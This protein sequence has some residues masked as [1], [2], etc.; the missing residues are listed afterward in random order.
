MPKFLIIFLNLKYF[1]KL[2]TVGLYGPCWIPNPSQLKPNIDPCRT[3]A[4]I[5]YPISKKN[6]HHRRSLAL[7]YSPDYYPKPLI[8]ARPRLIFGQKK[9]KILTIELPNELHSTCVVSE[10]IHSAFAQIQN[11][12]HFSTRPVLVPKM[13]FTYRRWLLP[14][15]ICQI[16][17]IKPQFYEINI[18][19]DK[20]DL[21][22]GLLNGLRPCNRLIGIHAFVDNHILVVLGWNMYEVTA[23]SV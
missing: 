15:I 1:R 22:H 12:Y 3:H 14:N 5:S 23:D 19:S 9:L 18:W 7:P 4:Y 6:S 11:V 10:F 20:Y 2:S 8:S 21:L 13:E 16:L 17:A